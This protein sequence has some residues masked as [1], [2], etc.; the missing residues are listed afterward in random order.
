MNRIE[1]LNKDISFA[2]DVVITLRDKISQ[3]ATWFYFS[4]NVNIDYQNNMSDRLI[5]QIIGRSISSCFVA[6]NS[7]NIPEDKIIEYINNNF[8]ILL[9]AVKNGYVP[10]V[11]YINRLIINSS[12]CD[13]ETIAKDLDEPSISF[14]K[15]PVTKTHTKR[16]G[17]DN[18]NK[19]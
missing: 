19:F 7:I 1:N 17:V 12:I 15:S 18:I 8:K 13:V 11:N 4:G 9:T 3:Q 2:G 5:S 16:Y 14:T 6:Y 10:K